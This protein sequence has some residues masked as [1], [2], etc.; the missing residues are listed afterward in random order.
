MSGLF[1]ADWGKIRMSFYLLNMS[2]EQLLRLCEKFGKRALLWRRKFTGLLPEVNRRR[3]YEKRG[4]RSIFE[5]AAKLAGL[6]EDQVRRA[7]N[8]SYEFRDKPAL[9]QLLESGGVGLS[10]LARVASIATSE[11]ELEL[12][13]KVRLLPQKA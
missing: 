12:A 13:G 4:C 9:R 1:W 2:D 7:L 11:N 3:L 10:K 8:L 5:F 6:S